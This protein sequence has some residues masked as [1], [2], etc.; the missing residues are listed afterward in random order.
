MQEGFS[1][2]NKK[3][4]A[5]RLLLDSIM[6]HEEANCMTNLTSKKISNIVNRK[7][8][9][10]DDII[11]VSTRE[12]V[13][14]GVHLYFSDRIMKELNPYLKFD[15]FEKIAQLVQ[16]DSIVSVIKKDELLF[17]FKDN[18]LALFLAE[19]FLYVIGR[20]NKAAKEQEKKILL[21]KC[22]LASEEEGLILLNGSKVKTLSKIEDI[23]CNEVYLL[24]IDFTFNSRY[25]DEGRRVVD[26]RAAIDGLSIY[27]ETSS[28]NWMSRSYLNNATKM[29]NV[30]C[31]AVFKVLEVDG[32]E[33]KVQYL[34][35]GDDISC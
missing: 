4:V 16:N 13:R 3:E 22:S 23:K 33:C 32:N 15:V 27:G 1:E 35:I 18:S 20:N 7:D 11:R 5:V 29:T 2:K 9:V 21:Y 17:Y 26:A 34:A 6:C 24:G 28:E 12:S 30:F 19:A 25:G 31:T 8:L 14:K 10:P